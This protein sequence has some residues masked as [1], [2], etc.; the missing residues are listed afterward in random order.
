M[1]LSKASQSDLLLVL[2]TVLSALSWIFSR[3][4]VQL[5]PPLLFMC[6]RFML[7]GTLL[8][9]LG[10]RQ[11]MQISGEQIWRAIRVGLVFGF[12]MC[13]WVLGL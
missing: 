5:M 2:V 6:L 1:P 9:V 13:F 3:E 12:A 7:A 11:L 10:R 8:A 4:A